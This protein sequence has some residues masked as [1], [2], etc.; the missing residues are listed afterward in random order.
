MRKITG[1]G[2]MTALWL[3]GSGVVMADTVVLQDNTAIRGQIVKLDQAGNKVTVE[4]ADGG[5]K[6]IKYT[7][8][9]SAYIGDVSPTCGIPTA[10]PCKTVLED[11]ATIYKW[12][13]AT[14]TQ[15]KKIH[16]G[17]KAFRATGNNYFEGAR[18]GIVGDYA[19]QYRYIDFWIYLMNGAAD[20]QL[21]VQVDGSWGKR[22]G[23]DGEPTYNG[24]PWAMEGTTTKLPS[25]KWLHER[26]D[27]IDQLHINPG[28]A[29]TGLAFSADGADVYYD[30][31][32]LCP[33]PSPEPP[34]AVTPRGKMVLEDSAAIYKW[35]DPTEEQKDVV[36]YGK[37]AF[38]SNGNDYFENIFLGVVG[39]YP[40]Q[41]RYVDFWVFLAGPEADIQLQI[42]VDGSWGKRWGLEAGPAYNG[43][44]WTM[45]GTTNNLKSGRWQEIKL[46]LIK[47]LHTNPGQKITGMAFSSDNAD[48]YYDSVYLLPNETPEVKPPFKPSG[49]M[50]ME[51]SADIYKWT[52]PTETQDYLVFN[53]KK[54]FRSNGND[55]FSA[56]LGEV[57][58]DSGQYRYL[59]FYAFF[60]GEQADMLLQ[61]QVNGNWGKRWGFTAAAEYAGYPWQREGTTTK[62]ASGRWLK[63][64]VDL[65]KQ[66]KMT[67]GE[68]ITGLAFSS[69]NGD[70]AYDS[71]Y[72]SR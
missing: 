42:Q 44:G 34:P 46:D 7:D 23:F 52:D 5:A 33:N 41:F 30:T 20:I 32:V 29:I 69:D 11:D 50:V 51:D 57:G 21:Q 16:S 56:E 40:E 61:V 12:T 47:Q 60:M 38:K 15:E 19:E 1:L 54:S 18:L 24:Y 63:I 53:G 28:Q 9:K 17:K 62:L 35:T 8:V 49:K 66:L 3:T 67:P 55:Y 31:V 65:I 26:L 70:V 39:D 45:E 59:T 58:N 13:D 71:V 68:T 37:A 36:A 4:L 43:Y 6:T 48:V 10:P 2:L 27:L 72:L 22:W 25:G 64:K 14:E